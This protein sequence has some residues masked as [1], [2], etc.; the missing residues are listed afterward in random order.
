MIKFEYIYIYNIYIV[1]Y[2][3]TPQFASSFKVYRSII[4]YNNKCYECKYDE[5]IIHI[6]IS[7]LSPLNTA[8]RKRIS[9]LFKFNILVFDFPL[10]IYIIFQYVTILGTLTG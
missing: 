4:I 9:S 6:N 8:E 1:Q 10:Y 2:S 7:L 5:Y 3:L